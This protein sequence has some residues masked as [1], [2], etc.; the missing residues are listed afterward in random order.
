MVVSEIKEVLSYAWLP[1][2]HMWADILTKEMRMPEALEKVLTENVM[3]PKI[4][5]NEVKAFDK[6][7][8]MENIRNRAAASKIS[9]C[10]SF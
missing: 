6:E 1:T 3:L 8:R 7:V 4:N 5:V 10:S 2:G 9:S